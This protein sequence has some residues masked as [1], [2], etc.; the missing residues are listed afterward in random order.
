MAKRKLP[1]LSLAVIRDGEIVYAGGLGTT[2]CEDG[3]LPITAT[4]YPFAVDEGRGLSFFTGQ[5]K[6][7][8]I[9]Y[10]RG[11]LMPAHHAYLGMIPE[12][13]TAVTGMESS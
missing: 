5:Y 6:G 12:A 13:R 2:C 7:K 11:G 10:H 8:Q 9:V 4:T 1:G 3:G